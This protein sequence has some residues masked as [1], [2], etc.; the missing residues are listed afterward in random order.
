MRRAMEAVGL[1]F[2]EFKD[3]MTFALSGGQRR[4]VALAGVLALEPQTL[5]LDEPTAGLDP[6]GR[7][8]ILDLILGLHGQ[9]ITLVMISHNMEELAEI[10]DRL[11]VIADGRTAMHGHARAGVWPARR[12]ACHG[13]GRARRDLADGPTGRAESDPRPGKSPIPSTMPRPR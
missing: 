10:C 5:V 3:R 11:Y 9:G 7:R 8:Q 1:G 13:A 12:T 6:Q 4:R 2:E